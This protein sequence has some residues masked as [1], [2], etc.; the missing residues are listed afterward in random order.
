MSS[1]AS[2][3]IFDYVTGY[4]R[5]NIPPD[6]PGSVYYGPVL[7]DV[8]SLIMVTIVRRIKRA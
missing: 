5:R 2:K 7:P 6:R 1:N 8:E 4:C 3:D